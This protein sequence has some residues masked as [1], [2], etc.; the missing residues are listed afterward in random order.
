MWSLSTSGTL[1]RKPDM[2]GE[3]QTFKPAGTPTIKAFAVGTGLDVWAV[4]GDSSAVRYNTATKKWVDT[5][6]KVSQLAVSC[7]GPVL[8]ITSS[9]NLW[10]YDAGTGK[11]KELGTGVRKVTAGHEIYVLDSSS[12]LYRWQPPKSGEAPNNKHWLPMNIKLNDVAAGPDGTLW[13]V[14]TSGRPLEHGGYIPEEKLSTEARAALETKQGGKWTI[15]SGAEGIENLDAGDTGMLWGVTSAPQKVKR[16][17]KDNPNTWTTVASP[18]PFNQVSVGCDTA[19]VWAT[20]VHKHT[21]RYTGGGGWTQVTTDLQQVA[22][23]KD[24]S[25][26]WGIDTQGKLVLYDGASKTFKVQ[27]GT[28]MVRIAAGCD[29]TLYAAASSG[30]LY[31][32]TLS[33]PTWTSLGEGVKEISAGRSLYIIDTK[34]FL[35]K[36][37]S[38]SD[39]GAEGKR[40]WKLLHKQLR[41]VAATE[42]EDLYGVDMQGRVVE[43][44]PAEVDTS[45]LSWTR[46]PGRVD[47]VC[48]SDS[49]TVYGLDNGVV[50]KYNFEKKTWNVLDGVRLKEFS[51]GCDGS[52]W[53]MKEAGEVYRRQSAKY[54]W[55]RV[56]G[57]SD[58][59]HV[60]VGKADVAWALDAAGRPLVWSTKDS[61][62]LKYK[63]DLASIDVACDG[64]A[65]GVDKSGVVWEHDSISGKW[66]KL[67]V[68]ASQ[69]A[70]GRNTYVISTKGWLFKYDTERKGKRWIKLGPLVSVSASHDGAVWGVD[71]RGRTLIINPGGKASVYTAPELPPEVKDDDSLNLPA[72]QPDAWTVSMQLPGSEPETAGD[73][74]ILQYIGKPAAPTEGLGHVRYDDPEP[75]REDFKLDPDNID[76][77]D[78]LHRP[79]KE[80]AANDPASDNLKPVKESGTDLSDPQ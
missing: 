44:K 13:G 28:D 26:V 20:S 30:K 79:K 31:R 71:R 63:G 74:D 25:Q 52:I 66:A 72:P 70:P 54:G 6:A 15:M 41:K 49:K 65:W 53:G 76:P 55:E 23:G 68:G 77:Q 4:T 43:F 50:L 67:G 17:N 51:C 12:A 39:G 29:G 34:G 9:G 8:S 73:D 60:G 33:N 64:T 61:T 78:D 57:S 21:Y 59:V 16:Y 69:V 46:V 1:Q 27:P 38:P 36:Y 22:V 56:S 19:T 14:S 47:K 32:R 5:G 7:A 2:S 80:L 45:D 18:E 35:F 42:Q 58:V 11:W 37:R 62:W 75:Q 10:Q 40:N 48:V 24:M 3:W